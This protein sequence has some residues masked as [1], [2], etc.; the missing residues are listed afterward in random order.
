MLQTK[1]QRVVS[2]P[3]L[4]AKWKRNQNGSTAIEMG[5]VALP[6]LM[7]LFGVIGYGIHFYTQTLVDHAIEQASR[8][9]Q[10]GQAQKAG[11]S[12]ADFK[13]EI[14]LAGTSLIDCSRLR[15]HISS[16]DTWGAISPATCLNSS[17]QL[18][19]GASGSSSVESQSGGRTAAVIVTVCYEWE[20][21]AILPYLGLSN[22]ENNSSLI[23]SVA[24][25]RSE[26]Y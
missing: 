13:E 8:V 11:L 10:T 18:V 5:F 20:L 15:V 2:T 6:F 25:F 23:Q 4:L 19:A 12:M 1:D 21:A 9:L 14:C 26:P 7:F 16:G 3:S 22:M 24:A 17:K